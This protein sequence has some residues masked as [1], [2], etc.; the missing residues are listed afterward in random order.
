VFGECL[1]RRSLMA[2]LASIG[3]SGCAEDE[4]TK[5]AKDPY[6]PIMMKDPLYTW[7]PAGDITRKEIVLPK[8]DN[9]LAGGTRISSISIE[10]A[11]R[12]SGDA[13]RL[14][15]QAQQV[16]LDAGYVNGHRKDATGLGIQSAMHINGNGNGIIILLSAP[17]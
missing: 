2:L 10:L 3:L 15:E 6:L 14:L 7:R 9:Q 8:N 5:I 1:S 13:T 12:T 4:A 11:Y 17:G 16:S